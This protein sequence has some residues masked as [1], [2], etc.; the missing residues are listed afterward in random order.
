MLSM[1]LT[2]IQLYKQKEFETKGDSG[3]LQE[4]QQF[5]TATQIQGLLEKLLQSQVSHVESQENDAKVLQEGNILSRGI[6]EESP[7][8]QIVTSSDIVDAKSTEEIKTSI[9]SNSKVRTSMV[10]AIKESEL[11]K[12]ELAFFKRPYLANNLHIL[13]DK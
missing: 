10:C 6:K 13:S 1:S 9:V 2:Q 11:N 5:T 3:A 4:V 8:N 12:V 7:D